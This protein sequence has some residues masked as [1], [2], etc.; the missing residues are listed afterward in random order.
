MQ[1]KNEVS[2]KLKNTVGVFS[3]LKVLKRKKKKEER[4]KLRSGK[5]VWV[6]DMVALERPRDHRDRWWKNSGEMLTNKTCN[7]RISIWRIGY[8]KICSTI[9][10]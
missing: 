5:P 6:M 8:F 7:T 3:V 10:L 9:S 1:K 4:E 2:R